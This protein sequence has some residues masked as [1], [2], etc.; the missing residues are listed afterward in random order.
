ML[1]HP[2]ALPMSTRTL[3][4][5]SQALRRRRERIGSPWRKLSPGRQALLVLAH[6]PKGERS[7]DLA[8]G[9]G[10][11][12]AT[13]HRYV[14]EAVAVLAVMAPPCS[15]PL[16]RRRPRATSS[17]T[18]RCCASTVSPWPSGATAPTTPASFPQSGAPDARPQLGAPPAQRG[19]TPSP[20][21]QDG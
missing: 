12:I 19:S 16:R 14:H 9:F 3:S 2:P 21:R 17:W 1:P 15:R 5:L 6:L 8:A 13:I 10:V 20:I 18:R 7:A 4:L 11:G